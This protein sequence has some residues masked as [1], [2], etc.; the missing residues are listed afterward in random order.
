MRAFRSDPAKVNILSHASVFAVCFASGGAIVQLVPI[1]RQMEP[2][3][4]DQIKIGWIA[5]RT[6]CPEPQVIVI[7]GS[8]G[9]VVRTLECVSWNDLLLMDKGAV[10]VGL[11]KK[12]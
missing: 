2:D 6:F 5:F 3:M 12:S 9:H 4:A 1:H 8:V 10:S 7:E 11:D